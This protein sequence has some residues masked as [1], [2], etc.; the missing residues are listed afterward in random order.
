MSFW[1]KH[2]WTRSA[3]AR[4]KGKGEGPRVRDLSVPWPCP[5]AFLAQKEAQASRKGR[6]EGEADP[7]PMATLDPG[8]SWL[9]GVLPTTY[10][11]KSATAQAHPTP[12]CSR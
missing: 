7:H 6:R 10:L 3:F 2:D 4:E 8:L 1:K 12:R 9:A 5:A 11:V